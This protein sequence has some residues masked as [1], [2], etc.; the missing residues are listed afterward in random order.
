[1]KEA[2]DLVD[3]P[4]ECME[5]LSSLHTTFS[6]RAP[7]QMLASEYW[8]AFKQMGLPQRTEPLF[9][10]V[11]LRK[12][13]AETIFQPTAI[14]SPTIDQEILPGSEASFIVFV[15][16]TYQPTLSRLENLPKGLIVQPLSQAVKTFG[17]LL[18]HQMQTGLQSE[19]NPFVL[20]NGALWQEGVFIYLPPKT[21]CQTALQIL[22]IVDSKEGLALAQPR[23]HLFLGKESELK[24]ITTSS[25]KGS[26]FSN[27]S[28]QITIDEAAHLQWIQLQVKQPANS[29]FFDS[30]RVQLKR[31][32]SFKSV[33]LSEGS[34]SSRYDYRV[35]LLGQG[36]NAYLAGLSQLREKR[37]SHINI[38]MEH[39][40]FGCSSMQRFKSVLR[41]QARASFQGKIL[42][43]PVAQKT[44]AFQL[45]KALLLDPHTQAYSK[46]NLEIFA[47]DVKASHGATVGQLDQE[48]L[49]YLLAR[50]LPLKEAQ[51]LLIT[52]YCQE[53]YDL[54]P[55]FAHLASGRK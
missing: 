8:H 32:S 4:K 33:L 15:N 11:P 43:E 7:I 1:V 22:H 54:V 24:V 27:H 31:D 29:W 16:G 13:Y 37:E 39:R 52:G 6:E 19:K 40:A 55:E 47:D 25:I 21:R 18:Q 51:D 46:P 41:D 42:V 50:G 28:S 2:I 9:R 34:V 36:C 30:L 10:Y 48:Q 49:F 3:S 20:L 17:G 44:E 26:S 45:S 12:L 35:S 5:R 38:N 53:I 23:V 14:T